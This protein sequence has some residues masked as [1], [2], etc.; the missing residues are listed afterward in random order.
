MNLRAKI[1]YW[2]SLHQMTF[3]DLGRKMTAI[4][5]KKYT[6]GSIN[7]KLV[8]GTL[9]FHE[10]EIIAKLFNNRVDIVEDK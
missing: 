10:V 7:A 6:G 9:T 5:G 8:R 1:N 2:L 4:T 3:K